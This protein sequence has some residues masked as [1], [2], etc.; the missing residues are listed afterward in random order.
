MA[1]DT[2]RIVV[3]AKVDLD[4][5]SRPADGRWKEDLQDSVQDFLYDVDGVEVIS[6]KVS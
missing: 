4:D 6:V 3:K 5:F 1:Y 2:V